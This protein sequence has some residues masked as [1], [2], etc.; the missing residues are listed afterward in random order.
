MIFIDKILIGAFLVFIYF[1]PKSRMFGAFIRDKF[2]IDRQ[3][4]VYWSEDEG[5]ALSK[6]EKWISQRGKK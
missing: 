2:N 6:A 5:V 1:H 3:K 4:K